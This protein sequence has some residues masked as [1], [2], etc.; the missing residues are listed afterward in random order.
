MLLSC[1]LC[2]SLAGPLYGNQRGTA[3]LTQNWLDGHPSLGWHD[4]IAFLTIPVILIITQ[5]ISQKLL[6]PPPP[7]NDPKAQQ[8]QVKN[9]HY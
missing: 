8:T 5:T 1:C 6:S 9:H 4:T 2:T 3:W 7:D